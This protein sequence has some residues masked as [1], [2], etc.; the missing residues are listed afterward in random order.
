MDTFFY[1]TNISKVKRFIMWLVRILV[2]IFAIEFAV[3]W[4]GIFQE[5]SGFSSLRGILSWFAI[6][7]AVEF[8]KLDT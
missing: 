5:N 1:F 8:Y 2:V 4:G 7:A 6:W 3:T